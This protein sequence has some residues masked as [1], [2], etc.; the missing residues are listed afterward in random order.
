MKTTHEKQS[1]HDEAL[2]T[3]FDLAGDDY[4]TG[5]RKLTEKVDDMLKTSL[6][7]PQGRAALRRAGFAVPRV[8]SQRRKDISSD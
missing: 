1:V 7:T 6:T 5:L 3:M 2:A 8:A 4:E